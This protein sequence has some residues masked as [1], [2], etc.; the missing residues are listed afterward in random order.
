[1]V[2]LNSI[3]PIRREQVHARFVCKYCHRVFVH[4]DRYLQHE[5]KQMKR[6]AEF[7]S[8][9][10]Q[11]A[12]HYYQNWMRYLKRMP[13]PAASFL[14]SKY[15]RTFINFTKFVRD[16]DLPRPDRFVQYMVEKG[17]TPTMWM[18]DDVYTL[19][20]E[21][22]DRRTSPMDQ[23]KL[24]IDTLLNMADRHDV[25]V[26]DVFTKL[27]PHELMHLLRVRKLSPWLLLLSKKFKS[28]FVTETNDEQ[29]III[30]SLVRPSYWADKF[31]NH[32]DDIA[33][34]KKCISALDI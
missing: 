30:E 26:S 23:A 27:E 11:A 2:D 25:D 3:M 7:K 33:N 34:I 22:L 21:F 9:T 6:E 8:P 20:L 28:Y 12:F 14:T 10:G 13:P 15:F 4:E 24:S 31:G 16:V 19:Y 18:S 32:P 29:K 1:M 17:F 5:C